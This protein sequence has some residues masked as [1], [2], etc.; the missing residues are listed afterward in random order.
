MK[1]NLSMQCMAKAF[2][3]IGQHLRS[4]QEFDITNLLPCANTVRNSTQNV[5]EQERLKLREVLRVCKNVGGAVTCDVLT[6]KNAGKK[7]Y[8][9]VIHFTE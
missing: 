7:Y 3:D 6:Q 9:F 2:I 4:N 5:C 1:N 8:D